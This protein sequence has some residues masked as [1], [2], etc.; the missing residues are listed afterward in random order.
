MVGRLLSVFLI[1]PQCQPGI[2]APG[3]MVGYAPRRHK[4]TAVPPP[5]RH[6]TD[7]ISSRGTTRRGPEA[8]DAVPMVSGR[9]QQVFG[10]VH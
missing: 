4:T 10:P 7:G 8:L 5:A 1:D 6:K 3:R 2:E 9:W